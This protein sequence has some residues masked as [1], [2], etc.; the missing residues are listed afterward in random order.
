MRGFIYAGTWRF[1]MVSKYRLAVSA[2]F[3]SI[4]AFLL[5]RLDL[6]AV[7][8]QIVLA[9]KQYLV[10]AGVVF[11]VMLYLKIKKLVWISRYY[12]YTM[13]FKQA[14]LVQMVGI[15]LATLTPGRIGEGSKVILMKK[16]L[17]IP[18]SSS[19][20]IIVLE[21]IL[22]IAVLS[23]GAFLLSFYIIKDMVVITGLFFLVL[24]VFLYLFL[25]QQDKFVG[26]VPEKYRGY[27]AVER[28][29]NS[30]LFIIIALSTF[31][32][33]GLEAA[34]QWLLLRSFDTSISIFVVF[35][36]MS[37]STIMV[38]FSVLPAGIG[39]VDA[40]YL[41]LYPLMGVPIE[42]AASV[43]LIY[44][45]LATST[46]FAASAVI[47]NYYKLSPGDIRREIGE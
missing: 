38:F 21:R 16:Y 6:G 20:S 27:L 31:S 22:D 11:F 15:A 8:A 5:M 41:L 25:K 13:S 23:A 10:V 32:I 19:F 35:G 46:P 29:S 30:P 43:L 44:R 39:T 1:T 9:K 12:S 40:S 47:L 45:F 42:V 2:I 24:I 17:K 36:I 3:L 28:K 7:F 26:L 4:L 37:I 14:T 18:V 33:W 34:F